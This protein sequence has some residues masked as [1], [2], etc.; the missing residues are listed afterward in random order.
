MVITNDLDDLTIEL[1]LIPGRRMETVFI[2]FDLDLDPKTGNTYEGNFGPSV[3]GWE[4]HL[5]FGEPYFSGEGLGFVIIH[6]GDIFSRTVD[7]GQMNHYYD[8]D[9]WVAPSPRGFRLTIP[10]SQLG[11]PEHFDFVVVD[12]ARAEPGDVIKGRYQVFVP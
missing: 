12:S 3:D 11:N 9:G 4:L 6:Q 1:E 7:D 10:L 5:A 8:F 2:Y